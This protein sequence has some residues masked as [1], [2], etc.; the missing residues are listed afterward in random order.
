[1]VLFSSWHEKTSGTS[2]NYRTP[3]NREPRQTARFL[4]L[5]TSTTLKQRTKASFNPESRHFSPRSLLSCRIREWF[6]KI[7]VFLSS[8]LK[9]LSVEDTRVY[10]NSFLLLFIGARKRVP[11]LSSKWIC[12]LP[13]RDIPRHDG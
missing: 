11:P 9:N 4:L 13:S 6:T 5:T 2:T 8:F 12:L 3:W 7:D 10:K 1:M